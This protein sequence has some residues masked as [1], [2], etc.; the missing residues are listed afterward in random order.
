MLKPQ[1]VVNLLPELRIGVDLTARSR[2]VR[3][4]FVAD[5]ELFRQLAL[6]VSGFRS[7]THEFHNGLS[8][9]S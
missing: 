8:A 2:W 1:V 7:E 6:S 4:R 3:K 9:F 5:E